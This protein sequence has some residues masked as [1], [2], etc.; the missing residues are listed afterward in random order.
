MGVLLHDVGKPRLFGVAERIRFD[1]HVEA[2]LEIA[3]D[4]LTR[5][6][7][8]GDEIKQIEAL[9]ANHMKFGDARG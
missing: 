3:H 2:G 8:S 5:L 6:R 4:I 1:G 7:F 9:V